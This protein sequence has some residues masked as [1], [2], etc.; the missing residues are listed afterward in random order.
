MGSLQNPIKIH[1][2]KRD[3][4]EALWPAWR[5]HACTNPTLRTWLGGPIPWL[6]FW[7][8]GC[9]GGTHASPFKLDAEG[10]EHRLWARTRGRYVVESEVIIMTGLSKLEDGFGS[11]RWAC[12]RRAEQTRQ[13]Q[14]NAW[15]QFMIV[16]GD[17]PG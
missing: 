14:S 3:M 6:G 15:T 4:K 11:C 12:E 16:T 10:D 5:I 17:Q 8:L 7:I 13:G 9:H 1:E 2:K